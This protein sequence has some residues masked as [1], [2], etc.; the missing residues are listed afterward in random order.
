MTTRKVGQSAGV[1]NRGKGRKPGVPNK[2]TQSAKE[3]FQYAFDTIGG[4]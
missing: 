2:L 3:A 1:G 4:S